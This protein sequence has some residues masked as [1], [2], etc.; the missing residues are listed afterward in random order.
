[1]QHIFV[2]RVIVQQ[3]VKVEIAARYKD[4]V[5]VDPS[6]E[7]VRPTTL[8]APIGHLYIYRDGWLCANCSFICRAERVI[9]QH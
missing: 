6:I 9:K 3:D 4:L 2:A 5:L 8:V 7:L 1:M